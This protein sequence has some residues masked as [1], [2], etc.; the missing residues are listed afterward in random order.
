M[1]V[2]PQ[3]LLDEA[4]LL[5]AMYATMSSHGTDH[6]YNKRTVAAGTGFRAIGAG[7]DNSAG[8]IEQITIN[9]KLLDATVRR[10]MAASKG[11]KGGEAAYMAEEGRWALRA[12]FATAES[13]LVNGTGNLSDGFNG[14]ADITAVDDIGDSMTVDA[15]G[16]QGVGNSCY[17]INSSPNGLALVSN[18]EIEVGDLAATTVYDGSASYPAWQLPI[19]SWLGLQI[20]NVYSISRIYG[21]DSSNPLTDDLISQAIEKHPVGSKPTH[22]VMGR[23][24]NGQLQRS[25]TATNPTG[26]P[27]PFPVQSF[28][29]PIVVTDALAGGSSSPATTTTT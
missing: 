9:L 20:G 15:G 5:R 4:P 13:Q 24:E 10:D 14:F 21:I 29:V 1:S 8:S 28:N 26:Q 17:L 7:Q 18:G 27:A 3:D 22:I 16:G 19:L 2:A 12:A 11:F 25:R 23:T 6:K